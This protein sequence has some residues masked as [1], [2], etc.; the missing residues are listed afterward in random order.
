MAVITADQTAEF[1]IALL[2]D[3]GDPP[4]NLKLQKLLYYGQGWNLALKTEKLFDDRI[5]AWPHGPVVP[6][7]YGRFKAFRWEPIFT[8]VVPPE[9]PESVISHLKEVMEVYGGYTA[10]QLEL[11]THREAP[12]LITRG[13]LP[14]DEPSNAVID[15][16]LM[17]QYFSDLIKKEV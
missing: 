4:T 13:D 3:A 17:R 12:W 11:M 5:E 14:L 1:L 16:E 2:Q 6:R 9:L 10:Y 7:V 8:E 15:P